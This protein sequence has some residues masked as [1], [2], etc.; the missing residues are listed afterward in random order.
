MYE[1]E[2]VAAYNPSPQVKVTFPSL[3]P[4]TDTVTIWRSA[5]VTAV[6]PGTERVFAAGGYTVPDLWAPHSV[7]VT[8]RA[9][10]FDAAGAPLGSTGSASTVVWGERGVVWVSDPFDPENAVAVEMSTAFG[11]KLSVD[12]DVQMHNTGGRVVS[13]SGPPGLF[14]SVDLSL[15]SDTQEQTEKLWSI[16]SQGLVLFRLAPNVRPKFPTV[17]YAHVGFDLID[18][19]HLGGFQFGGESAEWVVSGDQVSPITVGAA[20]SALPYQ[21]YMDAFATYQDSMDVYSTYLESRRNPPG[22]A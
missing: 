10:M 19:D 21:R 5:D 17:F 15:K 9:D 2:L 6:V 7:E 4:D 13:L 1:P 14:S 16:L 18:S 22:G 12:R 3:H 11:A 8:Y 20:V